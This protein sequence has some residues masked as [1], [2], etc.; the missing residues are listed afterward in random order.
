M[1]TFTFSPEKQNDREI[2]RLLS[3]MIATELTN[4]TR[5]CYYPKFTSYKKDLYAYLKI[6]DADIK[7]FYRQFRP[8]YG[9]F[10]I[11]KDHTTLLLVICVIHFTRTKKEKLA[12]ML[13]ELLAIKF[14]GSF[15]M[16]VMGKFCR[17]DLWPQAVES[18]SV[19]HLYKRHNGIPGAI[20]Y[21]ADLEYKK[22][23]ESF[24]RTRINDYELL[25]ALQILRTRIAQSIKSFAEAY[26]RLYNSKETGIVSRDDRE[27][28][29]EQEREKL[30]AD[31]ISNRITTYKQM[32]SVA[33]QRAS[34]ISGLRRDLCVEIV[35][36]ISTIEK[37]EELKFI[38][39][40][41]G[42]IQ[43]LKNVCIENKRMGFI[44]K[45]LAPTTKVGTHV[46]KDAV[47]DF[48]NN[49]GIYSVKTADPA[50]LQLFFNNYIT[51]FLKHRICA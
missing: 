1:I 25:Q 23:K 46:Y 3:K 31:E 16:K 50:S 10:K 27:S 45:L 28:E 13:Y 43:P 30:I 47:K 44:R 32:D 34:M 4:M 5:P 26:Y 33:F 22:H 19:K 12:T 41:M 2:E 35:R 48:M 42:R 29:S 21:I 37:K 40:L 14:Y 51:L 36:S 38:L 7:D 11:I 15:L 17:E 49:L 9:K 39:I 6:T 24:K 18:L 20:S 8:Q